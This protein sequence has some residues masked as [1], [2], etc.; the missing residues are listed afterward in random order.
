[1]GMGMMNPE[2][3]GMMQQHDVG[4]G[5]DMSAGS[6]DPLHIAVNASIVP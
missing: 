6:K 3:L 4:M 5:F 1:M 2:M